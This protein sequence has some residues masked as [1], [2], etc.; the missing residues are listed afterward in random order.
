MKDKNNGYLSP[1][2]LRIRYSN[3][4]SPRKISRVQR[5]S[6]GVRAVPN[7][8]DDHLCSPVP[9][10]VHSTNFL[11]ADRVKPRLVKALKPDRA[12]LAP[13]DDGG[14]PDGVG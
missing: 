10:V 7:T 6:V 2:T 12:Y 3:P 4:K 1:I 11:Y 14:N 13:L 5:Q 8:E 9:V